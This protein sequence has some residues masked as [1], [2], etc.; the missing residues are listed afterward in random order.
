M[1]QSRLILIYTPPAHLQI[2]SEFRVAGHPSLTPLI[3]EY[4]QGSDPENSL[5]PHWQQPG[6]SI[7]DNHLVH[8]PS[9]IDVLPDKFTEFERVFFTG[10]SSFS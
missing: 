9:A 4:A 3:T 6:R 1:S 7:L 10:A 5:G 2:Y 8:I